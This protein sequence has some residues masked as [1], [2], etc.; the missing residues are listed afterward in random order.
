ME[1]QTFRNSARFIVQR[2]VSERVERVLAQFEPAQG[3]MILTYCVA[4]K[5]TDGDLEDCEIAC[6]ELIAE[7]PE[8]DTAATHCLP[9]AECNLRTDDEVF[10]RQ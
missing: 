7:F 9:A 10:S 3:H 1:A 8:I 2:N 5:L 4:G 6:A